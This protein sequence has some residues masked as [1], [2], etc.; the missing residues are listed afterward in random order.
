MVMFIDDQPREHGVETIGRVLPIVPSTCHDHVATRSDPV[1]RSARAGR[2][3]VLRPEIQL[4]FDENWQDMASARSGNS[5]PGKA[6]R[7]LVAPWPD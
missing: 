1:W 2:D 4:V 5:S 3:A 6:S 7:L